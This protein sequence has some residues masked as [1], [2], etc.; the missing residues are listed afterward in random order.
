MLVAKKRRK[1]TEAERDAVLADVETM[2]VCAA[3]SRPRE[4]RFKPKIRRRSSDACGCR[5]F[6]L[7]S[8][9]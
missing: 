4:A 8:L 7:F 9:L 3:A 6:A 1:Y 2:G 5:D